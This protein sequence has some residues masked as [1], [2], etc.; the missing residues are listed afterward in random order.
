MVVDD[1]KEFEGFNGNIYKDSLGFNTIGYGT[2]LPLSETEATM[3]LKH[4]LSIAKCE[5]LAYKPNVSILP[6]DVQDI[7]LI[8]VY[9]LGIEGIMSFKKMW[10]ALDKEDYVIAAKE[11]LD[12]RWAK[13]TPKRAKVLADRMRKCK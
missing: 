7:I 12:S 13:Q 5:L 9:Q 10:K 3:L 2:K 4:R 8:M 6:N 1:I 11:M